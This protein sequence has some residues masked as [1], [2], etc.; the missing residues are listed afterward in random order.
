[1]LDYA[2]RLGALFIGAQIAGHLSDVAQA[3]F[4]RTSENPEI[5][6]D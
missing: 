1:M 3:L 6:F 5:P 4:C 2:A